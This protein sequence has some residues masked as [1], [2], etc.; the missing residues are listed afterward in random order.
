MNSLRH[1]RL[2]FLSFVTGLLTLLFGLSPASAQ[3]YQGSFVGNGTAQT[4]SIPGVSPSFVLVKNGATAAPGSAQAP[5]IR[6]V[7][8]SNS[9]SMANTFTSATAI[10]ALGPNGFTVGSDLVAN[11]NGTTCH[12]LAIKDTPGVVKAGTYVG[13]GIDNRSITGIGFQPDLVWII[14]PGQTRSGAP[15]VIAGSL[16][17]T[18]AMTGDASLGWTNS[19]S[20][21]DVQ[22]LEADGFQVGAS[23]TVNSNGVTYGYLAVKNTAGSFKV[24]N[25]TGDGVAGRTLTGY[26]FAPDAVFSK[27]GATTTTGGFKTDSTGRGV[28]LTLIPNPTFPQTNHFQALLSDG[29]QVG[30]GSRVNASSG[31]YHG[32]AF[33]ASPIPTAGVNIT[34]LNRVNA[35]PS[36]STTVNW[37]LT[38]DGALTGVTAGHFSLSGAAATGATIGTPTTGNGGLTWNIPVTTG[39]TDGTLTLNLASATGTS[40]GITTALPFTGQSYTMD[41]TAPTIGIS[42]PS[43]GSVGTGGSV[44]YTV[45]YADT[46]FSASTLANGNITLNTTGTANGTVGVSGSGTTRTVTISSITG[47]GTLGI[48]IAAGTA[49]DTAGNTAPAA[50]PS[51]TFNVVSTNADLSAL[52]TTAGSITFFAATT[53][54]AVNVPNATT[55]TTVTATRADANAT[56]QVQVNGG[57]FSA[58]TSGVASGAL[59]LNVGSNTIDVKVTAQDGTTIKTYTITV[60]RAAPPSADIPMTL[61]GGALNIDASSSGAAANTILRYVMGGAGRFWRF[62]MPRAPWAH[63]RAARRWMRTRCASPSPALPALF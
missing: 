52:S 27:N 56:L 31:A 17:R 24:L 28:D 58:L 2:P 7:G 3:F 47:A 61:S 35:T 8:M 4:I 48:S 45:T 19:F 20:T 13:N 57:G 23:A 49:S 60:T 55:S 63:R 30:S 29:I 22:A 21:D 6:V 25:W 14:A 62:S 32:F 11:E 12:W 41:K 42:A 50:G 33:K 40:P 51:T 44:T 10:T 54:Y 39:S 16:F 36:N 34:S 46:N 43:A 59:A 37:T 5:H 9:G 38:L 53:A 1:A 18:S 15:S 26:G